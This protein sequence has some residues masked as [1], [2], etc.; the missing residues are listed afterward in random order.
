MRYLD[1][2]SY[3]IHDMCEKFNKMTDTGKELRVFDEYRV[4][5]EIDHSRG[6]LQAM[7]FCWVG[8]SGSILLPLSS[9]YF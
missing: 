2:D 7:V 1:K 8:G 4:V 9:F 5:I 6:V 3:T